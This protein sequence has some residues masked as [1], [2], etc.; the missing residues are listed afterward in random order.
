MDVRTV[1]NNLACKSYG[2]Q[3]WCQLEGNIHEIKATQSLYSTKI[4]YMNGL[5]MTMNTIKSWKYSNR[6]NTMKVY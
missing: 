4:I 1:F 3:L 6:I 5:P 2:Y